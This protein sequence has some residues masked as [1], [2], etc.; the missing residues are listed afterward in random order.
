[1]LMDWVGRE[2]RGYVR[3]RRRMAVVDS[4]GSGKAREIAGVGS[5]GW[6]AGWLARREAKSDSVGMRVGILSALFYL[7]DFVMRVLGMGEV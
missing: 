6:A 1:M 5:E 3:K 7:W 2:V 4:G